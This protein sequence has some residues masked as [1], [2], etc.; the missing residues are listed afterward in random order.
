[1]EKVINYYNCRIPYKGKADIVKV[2]NMLQRGIIEKSNDGFQ[3]FGDEVV[4]VQSIRINDL[5]Y[6]KANKLKEDIKECHYGLADNFFFEFIDEAKLHEAFKEVLE[7]KFP[8]IGVFLD[9]YY[10]S[11]DFVGYWWPLKDV[12]DIL[13]EDDFKL[14]YEKINSKEPDHSCDKLS[15]ILLV[16]LVDRLFK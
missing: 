12:M 10:D 2:N 11:T 16:K 9:G 4:Y 14:C 8:I 7:P 13:T 15:E 3:S 1:M 6:E 5:P